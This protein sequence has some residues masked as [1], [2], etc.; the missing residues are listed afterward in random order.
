MENDNQKKCSLKKHEQIDAIVYCQE[1]N[2]NMC[3][4]CQ[5]L[6]SELFDSHHVYNLN[7][8]LKE[9]FTGLCKEKNH[10]KELNYFCKN[11][12]VLCCA[13]CLCKIEDK[14]NGLH[15]NCEACLI[16]DI[17]EEKRKKL[18][19]NI[20]LL[21]ELSIDLNKTINELKHFMENINENKEKLKINIQEVFTKIRNEL[22]KREDEL[23]SEIDNHFNK[24]FLDDNFMKQTEKLPKKINDSLEKGKTIEKE[25][26]INNLP[27]LINDCLNIENNIR[28]INILDENIKK[29]K[30]NQHIN[31]DFG[32]N[33]E[34]IKNIL[35]VIKSF[36]DI[37]DGED[38]KFKF[39]EGSNYTLNN[40]GLI[41]TKTNGGDGWNC[42]ILGNRKIPKNKISK[43]KIRINNFQIKQNGWNI[44]IGIGPNNVKNELCFYNYCWTFICGNSQLSLKSGN[45]S[46][47]TGEYKK[48]NKG[49]IIEVIVDR[50]EG[51]LSFGVNGK[52]YGLTNVKIPE[53]E[54]LY[55]VVLIN[56]QNQTVEIV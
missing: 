14:G 38:F 22:N 8:N 52:N 15:K 50:K 28:D 56:D 29:I 34:E 55:P 31:M 47:Y 21:E 13:V 43:W 49:D 18:K 35:S 45:H 2:K 51:N 6:H 37:F 25:W 9:I 4:K 10:N 1:C 23:L 3:N 42:T 26:N 19:E 24:L 20:K 30:E 16:N 46:K 32:L 27:S 12:N 54:E 53:N 41:A 44:L 17:Q 33:D 5:N 36:G 39:K 7:K 48:L 40:N 11:H